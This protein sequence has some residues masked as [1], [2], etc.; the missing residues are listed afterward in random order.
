MRVKKNDIWEKTSIVSCDP[1]LLSPT[2]CLKSVMHLPQ[3]TFLDIY[4]HLVHNP[5]PYTG[6]SLKSTD[7]HQYTA[8]GWVNHTEIWYL[9]MKHLYVIAGQVSESATIINGLIMVMVKSRD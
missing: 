5:S 6:E 7:A 1:Y 2:F 8:A 3:L 9:E 4:L